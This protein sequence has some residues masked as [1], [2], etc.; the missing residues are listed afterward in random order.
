ML[1]KADWLG[2]AKPVLGD[3]VQEL[4]RI[5]KDL[6]SQ[7][8]LLYLD[9]F[10]PTGCEFALLQPFLQRNANFRT[11]VLLTLNMPGMYRLA[12]GNAVKAGRREEQMISYFHQKLTKVFGG[13]YW[14]EI[15]WDESITPKEREF[16]LV[17]A[18]RLR[19]AE[20]LP[21]TGFCPIH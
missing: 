6:K 11:E 3:T 19:L 10:G 7:S 1:Q 20:Y 17:E 4:P 18:Y 15:M 13:D 16:R 8:I 14:Q 9:P 12:T 2:S 21:F 5:S